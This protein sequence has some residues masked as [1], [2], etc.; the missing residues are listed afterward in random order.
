MEKRSPEEKR[1]RKKRVALVTCVFFLGVPLAFFS[2]YASL[3]YPLVG[4]ICKGLLLLSVLTVLLVLRG[5]RK[6]KEAGD[7]DGKRVSRETKE[8]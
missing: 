6:K 1:E 2:V 8:N 4:M 5:R 3:F 7:A